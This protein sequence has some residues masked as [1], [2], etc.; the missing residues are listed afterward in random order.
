MKNAVQATYIYANE[1]SISLS[2][3]AFALAIKSLVS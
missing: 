1:Q 3:A 2:E